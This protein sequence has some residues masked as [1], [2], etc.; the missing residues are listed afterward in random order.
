MK[1]LNL[2]GLLHNFTSQI[3][4]Q[5]QVIPFRTNRPGILDMKRR[6]ANDLFSNYSQM[7]SLSIA[8][9]FNLV[10]NSDNEKSKRGYRIF[11]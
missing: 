1:S 11:E 7:I 4:K 2:V 6:D 9:S 8:W 5:F 3:F 10:K